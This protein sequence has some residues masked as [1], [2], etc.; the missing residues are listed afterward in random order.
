MMMS[1][2]GTAQ[3]EADLLDFIAVPLILS[4]GTQFPLLQDRFVRFPT[5]SFSASSKV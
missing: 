3:P 2:S 1:E 4:S 5:D